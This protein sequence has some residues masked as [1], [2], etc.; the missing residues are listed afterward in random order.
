MLSG[1]AFVNGSLL[2]GW[3][4]MGFYSVG[5]QRAVAILLSVEV[6]AARLLEGTGVGVKTI[7]LQSWLG[8]AGIL[9]LIMNIV[10]AWSAHG[11]YL[12]LAGNLTFISWLGV[13]LFALGLALRA[14]SA[15]TLGDF[16][17]INV[18]IFEGHKLII[19]GPYRYCR[20][21]A[22]F[23]SLLQV[24]GLILVFRAIIGLVFVFIF[25]PLLFWRIDAEESLL[26]ETFRRDY[27][28]YQRN[29]PKLFPLYRLARTPVPE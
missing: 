3:G 18:T 6:I 4:G 8:L 22:Y 29:V 20:H 24:I 21:P 11:R 9:W 23:G 17:S 16:F 10:L 7:A 15:Y 27:S 2:L 25:I 12:T 5:Y 1:I 26:V 19:K 13:G 28:E 14:W